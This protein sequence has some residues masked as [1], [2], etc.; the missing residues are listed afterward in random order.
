MVASEHPDVI[1]GKWRF[2]VTDVPDSKEAA[3]DF[4]I[5]SYNTDL[6]GEDESGFVL[7]GVSTSVTES[8]TEEVEELQKVVEYSFISYY[9]LKPTSLLTQGFNKNNKAQGGIFICICNFWARVE[10]RNGIRAVSSYLDV[11]TIN[12]QYRLVN[13]TPLDCISGCIMEDTVG[14]RDLMSLK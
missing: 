2:I 6:Y 12:Y 5:D 14:D 11:E 4:S 10:W 13:P 7:A 3:Y 8:V 1:E 9:I